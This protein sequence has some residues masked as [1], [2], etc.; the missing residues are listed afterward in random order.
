MSWLSNTVRAIGQ[1]LD[2]TPVAMLVRQIRAS[3]TGGNNNIVE[4]QPQPVINEL[5]PRRNR[6]RA[7]TQAQLPTQEISCAP[8]RTKK[9][10]TT[11][12]KQA[13]PVR[14]QSATKPKPLVVQSTKADKSPKQEPLQ[15]TKSVRGKQQ[16]TAS[17]TPQRAK[18]A[19]KPKP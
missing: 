14:Q 7:G 6:V 17:K 12:I 18:Q 13:T 11:G 3:L 1:A 8:T 4:R 19:K 9:S 16:T 15:A 5:K 2:I 10:S